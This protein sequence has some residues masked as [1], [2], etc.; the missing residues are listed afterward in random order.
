MAQGVTLS[1]TGTSASIDLNPSLKETTMQY[2]VTAGAS[3]TGFIQITLDDVV[4]GSTQAT[5]WANLSSG[6]NSSG[7]DGLGAT[8]TL[9]SP[10]SGVRLATQSSTTTG[11]VGSVT[12]RVLQAVSG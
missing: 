5:T 3:G 12:L 8:Y 7:V 9:L 4:P 1:S 10:I 6:I 2:V 11:I